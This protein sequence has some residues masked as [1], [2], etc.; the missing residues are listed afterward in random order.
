M[1]Q[2]SKLQVACRRGWQASVYCGPGRFRF[3]L[4]VASLRETKNLNPLNDM[5]HCEKVKRISHAT[6]QRKSASDG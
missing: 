2:A 4:N 3:A 6:A 5:P 1:H